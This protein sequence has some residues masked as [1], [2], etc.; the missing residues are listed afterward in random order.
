MAAVAPAPGASP[1]DSAITLGTPSSQAVTIG[2]NQR[3]DDAN[4]RGVAVQAN[5]M[6][7]G[8]FDPSFASGVTSYAVAVP[9]AHS[10]VTLTPDTSSNE[11]SFEFLDGDDNSLDASNPA[12]LEVD[13]AVN[14]PKVVKIK[15]TAQDATDETYVLTITRHLPVASISVTDGEV[16]EGEG[17]EL[18]VTLDGPVEAASGLDIGVSIAEVG[19]VVV[20]ATSRTVT[21]LEGDASGTLTVE[22]Q[23][24]EVW[25]EHATVTATID[26]GTGYTVA[27]APD[28]SVAISVLDNDFPQA[29]AVLS[30][31][32]NPVDEADNATVS[33]TV[34]V[35]TR[36]FEEPREGGGAILIST[37]A[38]GDT[39]VADTDYTA[40]TDTTGVLTFALADFVEIDDGGGGKLFQAKETV[41]IAIT[42]DTEEE[43]DETFT[44]SMASTATTD[45]AIELD[46]VTSET[47][48]ISANDEHVVTALDVEP[49]ETDVTATVTIANSSGATFTLYLRH[50]A[51]DSATWAPSEGREISDEEPEVIKLENLEPDQ[52]Y[53]IEA[54]LDGDF[55]AAKTEAAT[56]TTLGLSPIVSRIEVDNVSRAGATAE[57]FIANHDGQEHTVL[58]RY[59]K[60]SETGWT[61]ETPIPTDTTSVSF[62]LTG[63]TSDTEYHLEATIEDDFDFRDA[64]R[65][66]AS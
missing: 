64:C 16:T 20:G 10:Q 45:A 48:T 38:P 22:T 26:S 3:S 51:S 8:T 34:T 37:G 28:E 33:A 53:N 44:V 40:L 6:D 7:V 63:L 61:D 2:A 13:L 57:V 56:F 35:T 18:T 31:A 30:V 27:E 29:D 42:N 4:L 50:K 15:V 54:S 12:S 39:A 60:D 19:S 46:V 43:D 52:E 25:E 14:E 66:R 23:D 49:G 59:R 62:D 17:L 1:T 47:V 5:S 36:R 65:A 32:P 9:F 55:P 41:A 11:A 58:L 21:I 24:D